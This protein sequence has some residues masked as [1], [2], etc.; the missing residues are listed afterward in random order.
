M[1][2][3]QIQIQSTSAKIGMDSDP[4][5]FNISQP[6]AQLNVHTERPVIE[7]HSEQPVVIVDLSAMWDA[8]NGGGHLGFMNRIYDQSGQFVISAIS[9]TVNDYNRIGDPLAGRDQVGQLA[10]S[11]LS[12]KPTPIQVYGPASYHNVSFDPQV[13]KPEIEFKRGSVDVNVITRPVEV[14]FER[15]RL[16]IYMERYPSLHISV[17]QIDMRS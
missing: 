10:W 3:P 17:P 7:V 4:G 1:R 16:R 15:G 13:S 2:I 5:Q 14:S 8:L 6:K 9:S 12:E 11:R